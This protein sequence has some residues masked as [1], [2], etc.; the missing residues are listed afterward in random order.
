MRALTLAL[1]L[2]ASLAAGS[3][4]ATTFI[5]NLDFSGAQESPPVVTPGTGAGQVIFDDVLHTMTVDL[6]FADLIG[7]TTLAHIHAPTAVPFT[8][9][10][11]VATEL[12][13]FTG[14]PLGVTSGTYFHVFD[15]TDLGNFNPA[16]VTNNGG[17]AA[18]AELGLISASVQGRSYLNIHSSF[19]GSGE[20]RSFLAYVPEPGTWAMMISGFAMAGAMLRARRRAEVKI[21]A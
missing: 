6:Q 1:A 18:G 4:S 9:N 19:V 3:A 16:F 20:I 13:S 8:G 11:S 12:P 21:S 14:F 15:L 5:F 10:A 7:T 17:T 2:A